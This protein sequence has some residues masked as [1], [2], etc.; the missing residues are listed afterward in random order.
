MGDGIQSYA[1]HIGI[2]MIDSTICDIYLVDESGRVCGR[3][4]LVACIDAFSRLCNGFALVF[5][6]GLY[7]LRTLLVNIASDKVAY[8]KKLGIAIDRKDWDS[9]K[10]PGTFVTDQGSEYCSDTFAQIT[11]LGVTIENLPPYRPDLKGAVEKFFDIIQGMFK[12]VLKGKG[13]VE[14]DANSRGAHDYRKDACLTIK[15]FER[16]IAR[17]IVFYNKA[18]TIKKFPYDQQMIEDDI[19]PFASSIWE[20]GKNQPSANL[21][22]A[23]PEQIIKT[24]LP[25]TVG[26]FKRNGLIV[27]K[28]RYK[29]NDYTEKYLS[30][31]DVIAA[32]DPD[33][34]DRVW[35]IENGR[36]IEFTLIESVYKD[37]SLEQAMEL[38]SR[39][40]DMISSNEVKSMQESIDLTN[41]ITTIA[42]LKR[43]VEKTR[44]DNI[45]STNKR[46][47]A[48]KHI[49]YAYE[50]IEKKGD[51]E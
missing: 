45:R 18:Y 17:C 24:L 4:T 28:I 46:A 3:P 43:P 1:N 8:C 2:G 19:Q 48:D 9:D 21:I 36:F 27:N 11:E 35:L 38:R 20:W 6:G 15:D 26:R 13:V 34:N 10:L 31:G 49:E 7:S 40:K 47:R 51:D 37:R 22:D 29:N 23:E 50:Y 39:K 44:V 12:P 33:L 16:I 5:E 14:P 30:G 41:F 42:A 32:Y 25:R